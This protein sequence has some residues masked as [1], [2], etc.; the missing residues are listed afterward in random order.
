MYR[1][2]VLSGVCRPHCGFITSVHRKSRQERTCLRPTESRFSHTPAAMQCGMR[3]SHLIRRW[4]LQSKSKSFFG[5]VALYAAI[6]LWNSGNRRWH[7]PIL[8]PCRASRSRAVHSLQKWHR[9][10]KQLWW[11][12]WFCWGFAALPIIV[13]CKSVNFCYHFSCITA[14]SLHAVNTIS[15]NQ[16]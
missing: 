5:R 13:T 4:N 7:P 14:N 6:A 8:F 10:R 2:G 1:N 9:T 16:E 3:E 15:S 12:T 11:L